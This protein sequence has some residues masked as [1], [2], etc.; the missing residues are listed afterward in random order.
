MMLH[1]YIC[2]NNITLVMSLEMFTTF[3]IA[4][5]IWGSTSEAV[6]TCK[7]G[8]RYLIKSSRKKKNTD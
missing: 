5:A 4:T 1:L 8:Q 3:D 6:T 7:V 2:D